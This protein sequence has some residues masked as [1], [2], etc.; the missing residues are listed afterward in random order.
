MKWC[1]A[2]N[3][4]VTGIMGG[5]M[6]RTFCSKKFRFEMVSVPICFQGTCAWHMDAIV[7]FQVSIQLQKQLL[8]TRNNI[9][10]R[11]FILWLT[12]FPIFF[13]KHKK[14]FWLIFSTTPSSQA[15]VFC[16]KVSAD[17]TKKK[18]CKNV[19]PTSGYQNDQFM[20]EDEARRLKS[21]IDRVLF[22]LAKSKIIQGPTHI[23]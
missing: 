19:E 14:S 4:K 15:G 7:V 17:S 21:T 20:Y 1:G 18:V 9:Q 6:W 3:G 12:V 13:Q 5:V 8:Q 10:I 11:H 23:T 2:H 16:F 22:I